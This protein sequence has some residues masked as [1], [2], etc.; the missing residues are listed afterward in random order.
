MQS[1]SAIR[2]FAAWYDSL[3]IRKDTGGAARGTVAAAL[4]VLAHLKD[5]YDLDLDAH[6]APGGSQVKGAGRAAVRRI[7]SDFGETRPFLSEGGRTN[8]GALG[9]IET[10]LEAL[11]QLC[12]NELPSENRS[13]VLTELQEFLVNKVREYHSRQRLT[14]AY[15]PALSTRQFIQELFSIAREHGKEG[16]VAEYIVGAKLQL[17][18]PGVEVRNVSFSTADTQLGEPG[19]FYVKDTV[20]HVTVAPMLP[21]Y[22]KCKSN[23]DQGLRVYLLVPDR[24]VFGT[25]QNAEGIIPGRIGVESIESFVAQNLDELGSFSNPGLRRELLKLLD[26][27]NE[28]VDAVEADKSMLIEIP[29]NLL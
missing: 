12:L 18:F 28:R 8:R 2:V 17:R 10:M 13:A 6:R 4:V 23:L 20:F 29:R 27:Y 22:E 3:P 24:I 5:Q 15:A 26:L 1:E 11:G 9:A 21:V 16:P 7:L 25:R 19:D 14:I